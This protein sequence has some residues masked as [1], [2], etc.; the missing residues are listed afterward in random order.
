MRSRC[1]PRRCAATHPSSFYFHKQELIPE[2]PGGNG[3]L[4]DMGR[5][6]PLYLPLLDL[7][8]AIHRHPLLAPAGGGLRDAFC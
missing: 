6:A 4:L 8:L 5:R 3:S 7:I 1:R 2:L